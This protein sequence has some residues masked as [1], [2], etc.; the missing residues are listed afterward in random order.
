VEVI[1]GG[2]VE[3]KIKPIGVVRNNVTRRRCDGW[4]EEVSEIII[5]PEFTEALD[6]LE[7]FSHIYVLFY[8]HR[9]DRPFRMKIHPMGNPQYPLLGA[10]AT[11]TPNRPSRIALT[12]CKL[13]SRKGNVLTVKGLDAFDGSPLLDIKPYFS[14]PRNDEVRLPDWIMKIR[15]EMNSKKSSG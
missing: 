10:F 12:L 3:V 11:R 7:E 8:I 6:G 2:L 5:D 4:R 13:L 15:K 1:M 9:M 14:S